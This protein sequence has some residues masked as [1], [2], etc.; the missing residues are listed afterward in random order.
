VTTSL[1]YIDCFSGIAG[2]MMLGAL[3][4]LDGEAARA[5]RAAV[6]ALP[7]RGFNLVQQEVL[8][9]GIAALRVTVDVDEAEQPERSLSEIL[10]LIDSAELAP[11]ARKRARDMF[12]AL[13]AAEGRVHGVPAS[14]VHF[15]ELGAVDSIVDIV[16]VAAG[17]DALDAEVHCAHVPLGKGF[18]RCRHGTL[19][20]PAPA[21]LALLEGVPVVGTEVEAELVT[22]TGAAI[23]RTQATAFGPL[24]A[25]RPRATGWGAGTRDQPER[26]GL[27]RLVLGDP[28]TAAHERTC[29]VLV[30]NVD[31]MT[32]E[33]AA[34]ALE[35]AL[36]TGALDA[37]V[38]PVVMK[39]GRPAMQVGVLARIA[40]RDRLARVLLSETTTI[41]LRYHE[42][43][44]VE[45]DRRVVRVTTPHGE[46]PVKVS[47]GHG[48]PANVA[49]EYE[50]CRAAARQRGVP[51]KVVMAAATAAALRSLGMAD[52]RRESDE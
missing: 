42:V 32:A 8:R 29:V 48:V 37:W 45:L 20:L 4:H 10:A 26:P 36:D 5:I 28:V 17:L 22:P 16:G 19:P 27:L 12:E 43:G 13:A 6:D 51:L 7:L 2:D 18:V 38:T 25:M 30:A 15:H 39:K 9:S 21:T 24:P 44:R 52:Y 46:I 49:P 34:H 14:S 11:G 47:T 31:D 3:M 1:L 33:V 40:D 35:A 50:A 23:V 41:G